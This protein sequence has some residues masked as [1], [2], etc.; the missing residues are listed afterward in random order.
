MMKKIIACLSCVCLIVIIG[1][2]SL[3]LILFYLLL[4]PPS[5]NSYIT[6]ET[7]QAMQKS[8]IREAYI[9]VPKT[10]KSFSSNTGVLEY[11]EDDNENLTHQSRL[12]PYFI[13]QIIASLRPIT[14][15]GRSSFLN[16]NDVDCVFYC[17]IS[18][19][20]ITFYI[21]V[22]EPQLI[23]W[24]DDFL[25]YGGNSKVFINLINDIW[26]QHHDANHVQIKIVVENAKPIVIRYCPCPTS[27]RSSENEDSGAVV[28][29]EVSSGPKL[30]VSEP[31]FG[32]KSE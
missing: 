10:S 25:Y 28:V 17:W 16:P 3:I 21:I 5:R 13:K 1:T 30:P 26:K 11:S 15:I 9:G 14:V 20:P 18:R 7:L 32:E 8:A 29:Q 2:T 19:S 24:H 6:D 22:T 27:V 4:L 31:D 23:I 12:K